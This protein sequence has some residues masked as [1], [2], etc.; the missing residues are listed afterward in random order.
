MDNTLTTTARA[1]VTNTTPARV[2]FPGYASITKTCRVIR[3]SAR[4]TWAMNGG[5][6]QV[7]LA[8]GRHAPCVQ[9]NLRRPEG[10]WDV[11]A[12]KP[13][14]KSV[15]FTIAIDTSIQIAGI[16]PV[17]PRLKHHNCSKGRRVTGG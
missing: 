7:G 1:I 8:S 14:P 11:R 16:A 2:L 3:G 6:A 12:G 13:A 17:I 5:G 9:H 10:L 15:Q 4:R